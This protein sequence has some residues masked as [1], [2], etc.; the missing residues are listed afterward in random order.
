MRRGSR[1]LVRGLLALLLAA[2]ALLL[3]WPT[4]DHPFVYDDVWN[5]RDSESLPLEALSATSLW[6]VA[7]GHEETV[8]RPVSNLSYGFD[9][10]LS[11]TRPR[12]YRRTNLLIHAANAAAVFWLLLQS[13][14]LTRVR[15]TP[16]EPDTAGRFPPGIGWAFLGALLWLAHPVQTQA[17]TYLH[18]RSTSLATFF[19]LGSLLFYIVGRRS[20]AGTARAA[21]WSAAA[22]LGLLAMAS[23]EIA[24]VLPIVVVLLEWALFRGLRPGWFREKKKPLASVGGLVALL[25]ALW[26]LGSWSWVTATY[27][28]LAY[29]PFQRLVTESRVGILYLLLFFWPHP[30]RLNLDHHVELSRSLVEPLAGVASLALWLSLLALMLFCARRRL[31]LAFFGLAWIFSTSLV[32]STVIPVELVAEHRLYLSSVGVLLALL[33]LARRRSRPRLRVALAVVGAILAALFGTWTV[34]RNRVWSSELLLWQDTVRKSP[35]KAR[36]HNNLGWTLARAGKRPE[37]IRAFRNALN[38]GPSAR[39]HF[40]LGQALLA[41]GEPREAA[42][43]LLLAV[44]SMPRSFEARFYLGVALLLERRADE[45]AGH[46]R[47]AVEIEPQDWRALYEL[48]NARQLRGNR[49]Q[50]AADYRRA[51]AASPS[52]FERHHKLALALAGSGRT[53]QA[54]ARYEDLLDVRSDDPRLHVETAELLLREGEADAAMERCLSALAL[55]REFEPAQRLLVELAGGLGE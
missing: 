19:F 32:E 6:R 50:G 35:G 25:A 38:V 51:I 55:D 36:P 44:D 10:Y 23:K 30:S 24:L 17:V 46:L 41:E 49:R 22:V 37:A 52:L 34:E 11:G 28:D 9:S 8:A 27:A 21:A 29:S 14:S 48:A 47:E 45:A 40:N 12:S 1:G 26:L 54:L 5:L 53:A 2:L 42:K 33:E 31:P 3:Y 4:L 13:L 16:R 7:R 43:H 15:R 39:T 20:T 18:Q